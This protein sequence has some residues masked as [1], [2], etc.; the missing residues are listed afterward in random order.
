ML[1]SQEDEKD[2]GVQVRETKDRAVEG[3]LRRQWLQSQV[4][5]WKEVTIIWF[6]EIECKRL[7]K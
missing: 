6:S 3:N 7:G 1:R 5:T 4:G 2:E